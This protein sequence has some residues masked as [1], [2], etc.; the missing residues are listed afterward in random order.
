MAFYDR[1]RIPYQTPER[2]DIPVPQ[3]IGNYGSELRDHLDGITEY[4]MSDDTANRL[5]K[6]A[7]EFLQQYLR[8]PL[9]T[10]TREFKW[11][12][13][14]VAGA[15]IPTTPVREIEKVFV[16][17]EDD[18]EHVIEAENYRV[19]GLGAHDNITHEVIITAKGD[20]SAG[21]Y[22]YWQI[23]GSLLFDDQPFPFRVTAVCGW[24]R[25]TMPDPLVQAALMLA[26]DWQTQKVNGTAMPVYRVQHGVKQIVGMYKRSGFEII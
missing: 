12:G 3:A 21:I 5:V 22:G 26:A 11:R 23:P 14:P 1:R 19:D 17:D 15:A 6:G 25:E 8:R 10:Q 18:S 16:L 7:F 2:Y 24:E 20:G 9:F 4:E 13:I